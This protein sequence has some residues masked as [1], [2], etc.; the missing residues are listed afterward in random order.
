MN[1]I[2]PNGT[3]PARFV[4]S[5]FDCL[6]YRGCYGFVKDVVDAGASIDVEFVYSDIEEILPSVTYRI[7][8]NDYEI[9]PEYTAGGDPSRKPF[10]FSFKPLS[11]CL[12]WRRNGQQ[13]VRLF[14]YSIC[15]RLFN[16]TIL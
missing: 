16:K 1:H 3:V 2:S 10:F 9:Y 5:K 4:F 14:G 15:L 7:Q 6:F 12:V 11:H 8:S 13:G